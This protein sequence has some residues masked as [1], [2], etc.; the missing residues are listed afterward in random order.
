MRR[1]AWLEVAKDKRCSSCHKFLHLV[2]PDPLAYVL[3]PGTCEVFVQ[4]RQVL[5]LVGVFA[6][7]DEAVFD[8][9]IL[10]VQ[11]HG[12]KNKTVN[13]IVGNIRVARPDMIH[14][15]AV[16]HHIDQNAC[17]D[18]RQN[19]FGVGGDETTTIEKPCCVWQEVSWALERRERVVSHIDTGTPQYEVRDNSWVVRKKWV[20]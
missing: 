13:L 14:E 12:A 1:A 8:L 7:S 17:A 2:T 16:M 3:D 19:G 9:L 18:S 6:N 20:G 15:R 11:G 4:T 5:G 10:H